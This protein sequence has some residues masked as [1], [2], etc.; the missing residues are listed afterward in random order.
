MN[1]VIEKQISLS[2]CKYAVPLTAHQLR[3]YG[4]VGQGW[5]VAGTV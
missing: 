1:K 3:T 2:Q 5:D 4:T